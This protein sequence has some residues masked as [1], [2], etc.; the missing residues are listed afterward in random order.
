MREKVPST[1]KALNLWAVILIIW[2]LYRAKFKMP[3]VFDEFVAK[4]LVFILPVYYYI[5]KIEKNNFFEALL[6]KPKFFLSDLI[7]G[8]L[9]GGLFF[10][11][12]ILAN[13]LKLK[14][15]F[16]ITPV[17]DF[18]YI[19]IV[20][21]TT[22]ATGVSEEIL[23]RGFILKRLYDDSKNIFT[24]SFFAS[25]LFFFLHVPILFANQ[26]ITGNLLLFFMTT[27]LILSLVNS[28]IF[29]TRKS[30]TLPIFIHAFYNLT[31]LLF[32]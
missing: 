10:L 7:M 23:S 32:I 8:I 28:F 18:S 5:K 22:L 27:D 25:I 1:Q 15:I 20:F 16:F 24:S 17:F 12:A 31:F 9:I 11:T 13:F 30:L 26:K 6:I 2:A 19:G 14:K 29:L 3:E 4:P 21:A